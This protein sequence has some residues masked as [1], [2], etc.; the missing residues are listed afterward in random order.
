MSASAAHGSVSFSQE[1]ESQHT[2]LPQYPLAQWRS[3][4]QV[5]DR[6]GSLVRHADNYR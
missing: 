1:V 5:R 2:T 3:Y 4:V 6:I